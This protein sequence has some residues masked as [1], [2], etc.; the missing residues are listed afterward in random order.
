MVFHFDE[1]N[2]FC[3]S[4]DSSIDRW[5]RMQKRFDYFNM[6]VSQW[7]ACD[8]EVDIVAPFGNFLSF[9]QKACAQSHINI[10]K[11]MR[12]TKMEYALVLEDDAC[13][14]I[15]WINKLNKIHDNDD[16]SSG[17]SKDRDWHAIFLNASEPIHPKE[18]WV[19]CKEQYLTAGYIISLNGANFILNYFENCFYSSD[20]MTSRMQHNGHCYSFFPWLIIQEGKESNIGSQH[21]EDRKK[22]ED[23]LNEISYSL[24]NY[25]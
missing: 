19:L 10:Y 18:K 3:I 17:F 22:V 1:N 12:E 20:W 13:F 14:D 21:K 5:S 4:L 11:M 7:K 24:D 15:D 2:S 23:C 25:L 9:P 16:S 6:R 8:K